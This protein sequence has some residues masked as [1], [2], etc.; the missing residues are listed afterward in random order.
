MI[1]SKPVNKI[2]TSA[3]QAALWSLRRYDYYVN[4]S[5]VHLRNPTFYDNPYPT[6]NILRKRGTILPSASN[7]GW[8]VTG[9]EDIETLLRDKRISS[10]LRKNTFIMRLIKYAAGGIEIP[11]LENPTML[12]QDPPDHTRLR[13]LVASGFMSRYI[14]SLAPVIEHRTDQLL[15]QIPQHATQFDLISLLA[16]P[17]P[18]IVIA[19]MMGVPE[20]DQH[21]FEHWSAD[22]LGLSEISNPEAIKKAVQAN[23]DM[24]N[25]IAQLTAAKRLNPGEDLI[26][27]LIAAEAEGDRLT[28][29]ELYSTCI[30][31]L[32]AGHETT[33][34]LIGNCLYLLLK[35]ES[36][37]LAA[38]NSDTLLV[39]ALEE[40]LRYEPP[41]QNTLRFVHE[42]MAFRHVQLKP[43][44]MILLSIAAANR[45]PHANHKPDT[46]NIHREAINHLGFG[47]GIHLC[48][49]MSLARLEA[50]I[51]LQKVFQRFPKLSLV[52]GKPQW[53][54]NDFF[55]GLVSLNLN[56]EN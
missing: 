36:Q 17:L 23:N 15:A 31:L 30:L 45:D 8:I 42:P 38:R 6:Y 12:N 9:Y 50:K 22:L 37:G 2:M 49:G 29:N 43:G 48:L 52:A 1:L 39:K 14:Q 21:Q 7:R 34:R 53:G 47:H 41:V 27:Q 56:I 19:E 3:T 16:K 25:Y 32:T 46:F 44:Q 5:I 51:A 20:A 55:R 10:D 33:T 35:H 26:S 28:L 11:M 40:T 13:K 18:A 54:S 24:R 4:N